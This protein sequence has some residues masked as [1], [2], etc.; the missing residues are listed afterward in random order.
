MF[1]K[2]NNVFSVV[3]SDASALTS[4]LNTAV[5]VG[6]VVTN[7]NLPIGAVAVCDMGMRRL[8]NTSY[9][10]LAATDKFFIVQGK[11]A[12]Q[13]L[14]KSPAMTKA[15]V[16]I[17]AS[18]FKAAVQQVNIVGYN[19][20]TGALPA[21]NNTDFWIKVRK[22][23]NDA[24]NR[25]QPMSEFAGPVK[26]DAT[27]TQ[28]ELAVA[29]VASGY[30]NFTNQEPA[31]G[32]LKLEAITNGSSTAVTG[33][34][35]LTFTYKSKVV[36]ITGSATSNVAVGDFLR[37][38]GATVTNAV[39]RVAAVTATAITLSTFFVGDTATLAVANVHVITAAAAATA[40]FGV[41]LTGVE[42]PFNVNSFRDYYAN[43]FTTTF[44]DSSALITVTGAQN[45]NGVWQQ[46]A[47]D[48]Y[49]NYGFE[50]QNDQQSTPSVPRDQVVKIP[51]VAGN[52]A[53]SSRYSTLA[54]N[55]TEE[56][57]GLASVNK[58]QG[59]VILHCN[60]TNV[61]TGVITATT[62]EAVV[63]TLFSGAAATAI[64]AILNM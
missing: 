61:T 47:M 58:P 9:A 32:Y 35:S 64:K 57:L 46:V 55:W 38:G 12:T 28:A 20:T 62:A 13:P 3:L 30:R 4:A 43:R 26:T 8:D 19:G 53:Q 21:A 31:N 44:S 1:R 18:K 10:A 59:S 34:T 11:G 25:S 52:T 39:Y 29:L 15:N 56:I 27:G 63:D 17:S 14:M 23:D 24:A 54:F 49:L 22:R 45:G 2:A 16:T 50:G 48:E 7:L 51:G 41:R 33:A 36:A 40:A 6:T 5:P 60:L 42:A 37:I